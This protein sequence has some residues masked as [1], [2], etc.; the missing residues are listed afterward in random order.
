MALSE[1]D[2]VVAKIKSR[3]AGLNPTAMV[4]LARD[5]RRS[6][7]ILEAQQMLVCAA[8]SITRGHVPAYEFAERL[9]AAAEALGAV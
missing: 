6:V 2:E 4:S 5:H 9:L 8:E 7:A 1:Q 3:I